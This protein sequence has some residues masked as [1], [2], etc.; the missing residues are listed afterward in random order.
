MPLKSLQNPAFV[1]YITPNGVECGKRDYS[2]D[3]C[4]FLLLKIHNGIDL[5]WHL[6]YHNDITM[7]ETAF[8]LGGGGVMC[9]TPQQMQTIS[10]MTQVSSL[11]IN[12]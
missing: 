5:F 7:F 12:L 11:I 3:E 8:M 1:L 2:Y 6:H 10:V 9:D 4:A